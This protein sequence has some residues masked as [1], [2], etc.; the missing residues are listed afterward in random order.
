[1]KELQGITVNVETKNSIEFFPFSQYSSAFNHNFLE[2]HNLFMVRTKTVTS[3]KSF[4][5]DESIELNQDTKYSQFQLLPYKV[6]EEYSSKGILSQ[7]ANRSEDKTFSFTYI[8]ESALKAIYERGFFMREDSFFDKTIFNPPFKEDTKYC[9]VKLII[10]NNEYFIQTDD[11]RYFSQP[12]T[13]HNFHTT[14]QFW[15]LDDLLNILINNKN[16][17]FLRNE[18]G[19]TPMIVDTNN[20]E[21][22][23]QIIC[24]TPHYNQNENEDQEEFSCLYIMN[25]DDIKEHLKNSN[26]WAKNLYFSKDKYLTDDEINAVHISDENAI[27]A[28]AG[29]GLHCL[30]AYQEA[31]I[32]KSPDINLTSPRRFKKQSF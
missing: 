14:S 4:L 19:A 2:E 22:L 11:N 5:V 17:L 8:E 6:L 28:F 12:I 23:Q 7:N 15:N 24:D 20:P 21:H 3:T 32:K 13:F 10:H 29:H 27:I 30:K 1:M 26:Q 18:Y 31:L 25:N 16:F 9:A